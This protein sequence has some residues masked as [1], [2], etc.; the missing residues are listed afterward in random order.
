MNT[1]LRWLYEYDDELHFLWKL[2]KQI[3]ETGDTRDLFTE[4]ETTKLRLYKPK[5]FN[6]RRAWTSP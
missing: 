4:D 3:V 2:K 6:Q 1:F 5:T